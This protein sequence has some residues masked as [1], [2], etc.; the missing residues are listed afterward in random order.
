MKEEVLVGFGDLFD[1]IVTDARLR[2]RVLFL[3]ALLQHIGRRLQINHQV[4]RGQLLAKVIVVAVVNLELRVTQID[5]GEELVL[6]KDVVGDDALGRSGAG[7]AVQ[8]LE[9]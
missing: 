8:L 4:R 2:G 7:K 9:A 5:A 6:L 1:V 3:H